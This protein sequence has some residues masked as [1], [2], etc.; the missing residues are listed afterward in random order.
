MGF[1]FFHD[2]D[3]GEPIRIPA[4]GLELWVRLPRE[5]SGGQLTVIETVNAAGFGPPLHR[6]PQTEIF[7]VTWGRYLFEVEGQRFQANEGDVVCV[8]GGMAHAFVNITQAP[9]H[10]T[11]LIM[12]GM[13]A[14]GFFTGLGEVMRNG[15]PDPAV[16]A[17][18]GKKWDV[19]FLG[20]PI[21]AG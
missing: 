1:S 14:A 15:T 4:I 19:D 2:R 6:H 8:P 10:Q 21:R 5:V 18:F 17:A 9:A 7:R 13:D 11:V 20:P 12:P 3:D 16:L